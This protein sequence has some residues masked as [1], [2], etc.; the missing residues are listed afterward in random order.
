MG[1]YKVKDSWYIDFYS[2]GR[3]IRKAVKGGSKKDAENA[4]FAVKADILR[5]EYKFKQDHMTRF[6]DFAKE[7]LEYAKV[8]KRSWTRDET[9]LKWLISH[10]K[11]FR[12]SKITPKHIED[13]KK[14]RLEKVKPSTINRE[15]MT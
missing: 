15:L 8:N 10:L 9:S 5:G 6:E 2:D 12:L 3:R 7:Y 14:A 4:L 11:D 1:I 13:Y